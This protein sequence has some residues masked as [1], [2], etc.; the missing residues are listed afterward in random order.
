M[1]ALMSAAGYLPHRTVGAR[2]AVILLTLGLTLA[3]CH[4]VPEPL[5]DSELAGVYRLIGVDDQDLPATLVHGGAITEVRSGTMTFRRDGTCVSETR[6]VA[7]SG[8]EVG[9]EV[10]ADVTRRGSRLEM[11]WRGAG[12]TEGA[13]A[14]DGFA[15]RNEGMTFRYIRETR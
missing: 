11:R 7:P 5:P 14:G 9:R 12:R 2:M 6:F 8:Q 13:M 3:G 15:M 10:V 1:K 4:R